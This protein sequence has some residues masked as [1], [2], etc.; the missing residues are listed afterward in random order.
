MIHPKVA[1]GITGA[2]A[3]VVVSNGLNPGAMGPV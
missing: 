3:F 2:V 1:F